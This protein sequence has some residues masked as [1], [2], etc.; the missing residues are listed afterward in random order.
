M[1]ETAANIWRD[2]ATDG[3]AAS[4]AKK[5]EKAKIREWGTWVETEISD[6][7]TQIDGLE[8]NADSII[9][10]TWAELDAI[11][12]TRD[13]Q[14]G[15]VPNSD[16]GTHTDPVVGGTVDNAGTFAWSTAEEGWERVD[17][18]QD[19]A[20]IEAQFDAAKG[21]YAT[22]PDRLDAI[23]PPVTDATSDRPPVLIALDSIT[24]KELLAFEQDT[25]TLRIPRGLKATAGPDIEAAFIE[26]VAFPIEGGGRHVPLAVRPSDGAVSI[27]FLDAA[28]VQ[29]LRSQLT[30]SIGSFGRNIAREKLV[31]L[32]ANGQSTVVGGGLTYSTLAGEPGIV[33]VIPRTPYSLMF[34]TGLLG[35]QGS[36]L[37]EASLVD[38]V[39]AVEEWYLGAYGETPGSGLMAQLHALSVAGGAVGP[40][41]FRTH[42][43]AG[44]RID[45]LDKAG[46][47]NPYENG[48]KELNQ[49][50]AIALGYGYEIECPYVFWEQ[51]EADRSAGTTKA[52]YKSQFLQLLS[53]YRNDFDAVLPDDAPQVGMII[54]QLCAATGGSGSVI[55]VAHYELA[56]DTSGVLLAC[57]NYVFDMVDAVHFTAAANAL[58]G[59]YYGK[60]WSRGATQALMPTNISRVGTSITLNL[61]PK[62]GSLVV[63]TTTLPEATDYG[64]TY[65]GANITA[66]SITDAETGQ[67]TITLDASSGGTLRY[68]YSGPGATGR[69][70]AWGNLCDEDDVPSLT[71]PGRM[72]RNWTAIFEETVA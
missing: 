7:N 43:Q 39:P 21:D 24:G 17:D 19:V 9:K 45:E 13:G 66:V 47:L 62:S 57:P 20:A 50:I 3:I 33:S 11:T 16:E 10:A 14:R 8:N 42:G 72:L 44:R 15:Y 60:C 70:G 49:A 63:D 53:D 69:S 32:P 1:V 59:E 67:V 54:G 61:T 46:G 27:S 35:V 6:I 22:L 40:M 55:S 51:G 23:D 2:F 38:F 18:Y 37:S 26:I 29:R 5:P 12:G 71:S 31:Y 25:G 41:V 56:R 28:S 34:N 30:D 52:S 64:F 4:G 36:A 48:L 65:V 68:A 58:R